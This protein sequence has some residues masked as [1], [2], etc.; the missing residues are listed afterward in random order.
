MHTYTYTA[1]RTWLAPH[2][3][4]H[5]SS[6]SSEVCQRLHNVLLSDPSVHVG[7]ILEGG[8]EGE[9]QGQ[10]VDTFGFCIL[11]VKVCVSSVI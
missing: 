8:Q 7:H 4:M 9:A 1:E 6:S 11:N 10:M 5:V 2:V 3:L